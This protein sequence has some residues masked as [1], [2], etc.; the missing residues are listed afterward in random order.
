MK[1]HDCKNRFNDPI[2]G[3]LCK[4]YGQILMLGGKEIDWPGAPVD[5]A[6]SQRCKGDGYE[7]RGFIGR[8]LMRIGL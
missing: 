7:R 4:R 8:V 5:Y 2:E 1:C 6:Y 3:D